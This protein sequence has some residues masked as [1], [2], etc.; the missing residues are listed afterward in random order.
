VSSTVVSR[1]LF[2]LVAI[3]SADSDPFRRS[4]LVEIPDSRRSRLIPF[5]TGPLIV[6]QWRLRNHSRFLFFVE[7]FFP[8]VETSREVY[9][10]PFL[11]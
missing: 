9:V 2:L 8:L 4:S 7:G 5:S 1:P 6:S 11:F 10:P 3:W